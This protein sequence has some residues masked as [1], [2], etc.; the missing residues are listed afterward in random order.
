MVKMSSV[1]AVH[2]I[3]ASLNLEIEQRDVK[4][5]FLQG[6]MKEENYMEKLEGFEV[7]G[8]ENLVCRLKKSLYSLKQA[9]R[10][11]Y[12]QFDLF[13]SKHSTRNV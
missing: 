8:K 2:E 6:D 5:A 11:W 12:K 9:P 4:I 13:M 7:K 1:R 10:L 3:V